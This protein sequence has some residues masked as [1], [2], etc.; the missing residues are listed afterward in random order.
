MGSYQRIEWVLNEITENDRVLDLGCIQHT[1]SKEIKRN[2]LHKKLYN[3]AAYVLGIDKVENDV[4]ILRSKGYNIRYGDVEK[5]DL[6]ETFDVIVAGELI[7]HLSNPGLFLEGVRKHLNENGRLIITSPNP[8]FFYRFCQA[9]VGNVVC[10]VEHICYYDK[11]TIRQLLERFGFKVI[12]FNY[13]PPPVSTIIPRP[14][15]GK[16]FRRGIAYRVSL[17]LYKRGIRTLGGQ[18]MFIVASTQET[19]KQE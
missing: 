13:I 16:K 14:L 9:L 18:G 15:F 2:W 11:R 17:I 4:E 10:N 3:K 5:L 12:K 19:S 8:F 1:A 6:G 7:E